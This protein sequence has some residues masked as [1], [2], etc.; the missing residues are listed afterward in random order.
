M[1][2][3]DLEKTL[4]QWCNQAIEGYEGVTGVNNF[5]RAWQSGLAFNA[6]IHAHRP[7]LFSYS[8][9]LV[10]TSPAERLAHAFEVAAKHLHIEKLLDPNGLILSK[11]EMMARY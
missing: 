6:L 11:A 5:T 4:L 9:V 10:M 1:S 3:S 2:L 7:A 8:D